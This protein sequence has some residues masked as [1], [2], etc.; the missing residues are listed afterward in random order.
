L[1][2]F[3]KDVTFWST[4]TFGSTDYFNA[5][6]TIMGTPD[7]FKGKQPAEF[8][9]GYAGLYVYAPD[10]YRE[11][12]QVELS[13][14]LVAGRKYQVSFYVSLAEGSD[15]AIKEFGVLFSKD[16]L[17]VNTDQDLSKKFWYREVDNKYNYMEIGYKNFYAD[18]RDWILVN[19]QFTAKGSEKY[20]TLGNFKSNPRT[21]LFMTKRKA[22]QG[23]YY[24]IDM[25]EVS[26]VDK[27][28]TELQEV[29]EIEME[30]DKAEVALDEIHIFKNVL[31]EFDRTALLEPSKIELQKIYTLLHSNASLNISI[32]GHTDNV[33][34]P[35]YNQEL[36]QAR[37]AA[38]ADYLLQLGIHKSRI[39]WAG[40]GR[41]MPIADND[42]EAGRSQNRRVEFVISKPELGI[43]TIPDN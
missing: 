14:R 22:G 5:C 37:A 35:A 16:R 2:N 24:Y 18:T 9:E 6:S 42:N 7:N 43:K 13:A 32:N 21:R 28:G 27:A 36:S 26:A 15:S 3:D 20:L 30:I 8:G 31:F 34:T 40:H 1:G 11:Y 19:T 29:T 12:L 25:V 10:D 33:G 38:V 17:E 23:A 39:V 41:T 4:P